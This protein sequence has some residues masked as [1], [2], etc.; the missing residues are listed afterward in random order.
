MGLFMKM[1]KSIGDEY[2]K[3]LKKL[4]AIS[5]NEATNNASMDMKINE[6]TV[7]P[8]TYVGVK[9]TVSL[10]KLSAFFAENMPHLFTNAQAAKLQTSGPPSGLYFTYDEKE[11]K[12]EVAAVAPVASVKGDLGSLQSFTLK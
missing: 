10:D 12:T 9:K 6:I 7:E 5:E 3:G 2:D 1:E 8:K 11:M 4:K